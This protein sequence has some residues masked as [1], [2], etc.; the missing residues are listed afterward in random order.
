MAPAQGRTL[1]SETPRAREVEVDS[2]AKL[3]VPHVVD[4]RQDRRDVTT[5]FRNF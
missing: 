2:E 4:R 3:W 1:P 5:G